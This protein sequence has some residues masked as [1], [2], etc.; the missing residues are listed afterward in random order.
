[1]CEVCEVTLVKNSW[2]QQQL[3]D[4]DNSQ[5]QQQLQLNDKNKKDKK[6]KNIA[7]IQCT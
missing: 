4:K 3:N 7:E 6:D 5:G 1:M 2:G